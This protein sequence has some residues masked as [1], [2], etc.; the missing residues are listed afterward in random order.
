VNQ[1]RS[2]LRDIMFSLFFNLGFDHILQGYDHLLFIAALVLVAP[3][4]R[5]LLSVISA[6]T[7]AHSTTLVL[8]SLRII[9]VNAAVTEALIAASIAYV[10]VENIVSHTLRR[11]WIIA[12]AFGLI[13]GAGFSGHLTGILQA[14]LDAGNVFS[15]LMGFNLGIEAG[16]ITVITIVFPLLWY[17]R[18]QRKQEILVPEISRVIAAIG[19]VLV[20]WRIWQFG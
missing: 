18:K 3:T 7:V 20:V 19:A 15:S 6:F 2:L 11:R 9:N 14:S 5:S 8:C 10:G 12:G 16:Q 13:H 4:W 17:M 1:L